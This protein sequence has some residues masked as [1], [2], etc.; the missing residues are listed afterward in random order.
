M[1]RRGCVTQ[2]TR[3]LVADKLG[4]GAVSHL[5]DRLRQ[6]GSHPEA[7]SAARQVAPIREKHTKKVAEIDSRDINLK[8][9]CRMHSETILK[10]TV[11]NAHGIFPDEINISGGINGTTAVMLAGNSSMLNNISPLVL[12]TNSPGN[13]LLEPQQGRKHRTSFA[14]DWSCEELEVLKRGLATYAGEP[15]IMK[16][17]KIA[18]KLPD[19]TVRDVAMRC[20]WMTKKENG[21]RRKPEDYYAG[22]KTNDRKEKAIGTSSMA[23]MFCNQ[24][25]S[26][27]T[28][29]FKMHN[30]N[31]NNQFS[32]EAGPVIDSRTKHLLEDNVKLFHEIAVNLENNE[33]QNN[34]DLLYRSNE[35][36]TAIL[37]SMSGMPG[38]MSQMP[39]LPVYANENLMHSTF[40]C[41]NQAHEPSNGHLKEER[42]SCDA[43]AACCDQNSFTFRGVFRNSSLQCLK[44]G[45]SDDPSEF[46][47]LIA[48]SANPKASFNAHKVEKLRNPC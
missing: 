14:V 39:P 2:S 15:N 20:R 29:S 26:E 11:N 17:I 13:I 6:V 35:N 44:D 45:N 18:S 21:K 47:Q 23:N 28:Y 41:I 9:C 31:H 32:C 38:I 34:I 22:K 10:G 33:I 4:F 16:Y 3:V 40:P 1:G 19:K 7:G 43:S 25:E 30:G 36:I 42:R 24:P 27:A 8:S 48:F 5:R 37:N 46:C 12:T